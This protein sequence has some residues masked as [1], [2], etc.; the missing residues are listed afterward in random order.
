MISN[1]YWKSLWLYDFTLLTNLF[2]FLTQLTNII[3][4]KIPVSPATVLNDGIKELFYMWHMTMI[5]EHVL[6]K[7]CGR[8]QQIRLSSLTQFPT[9]SC[10]PLIVLKNTNICLFRHSHIISGKICYILFSQMAQEEL[11]HITL[12]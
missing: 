1:V 9:F 3:H 4:W 10:W 6:P 12:F 5:F 11:C 7:K 8:C 2:R